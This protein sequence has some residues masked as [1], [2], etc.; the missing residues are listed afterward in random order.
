MVRITVVMMKMMMILP[1]KPVSRFPSKPCCGQ[2][3]TPDGGHLE[4]HVMCFPGYNA[5]L[6]FLLIVEA[7]LIYSHLLSGIWGIPQMSRSFSLL[8]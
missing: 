8:R 6:G 4:D 5:L 1:L 3:W 2:D 7:L